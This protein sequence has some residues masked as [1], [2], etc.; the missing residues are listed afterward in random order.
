M[1]K[2]LCFFGIHDWYE[3]AK[4]D[5]ED[6]CGYNYECFEC[7]KKKTRWVTKIKY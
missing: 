1:Y 3:L 4:T 2:I 6:H 5:Q 7:K